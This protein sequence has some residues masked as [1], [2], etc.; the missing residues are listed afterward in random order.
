MSTSDSRKTRNKI[1]ESNN[2]SMVDRERK[3]QM[4]QPYVTYAQESNDFIVFVVR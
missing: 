2:Y 1:V 4:H 3:K